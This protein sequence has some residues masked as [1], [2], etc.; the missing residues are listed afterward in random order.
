MWSMC[1]HSL[2]LCREGGD[3]R[4]C[5]QNQTRQLACE[6]AASSGS[7]AVE[8]CTLASA[9]VNA[10]SDSLYGGRFLRPPRSAVCA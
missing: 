5:T 1:F 7:E 8:R 10:E 6:Q 9:R 2:G 4:K 3:A